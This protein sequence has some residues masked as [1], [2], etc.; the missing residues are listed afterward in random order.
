MRNSISIPR[1]CYEAIKE[2]PYVVQGEVWD[3]VFNYIFNDV[4]TPLEGVSRSAFLLIKPMIEPKQQKVS[5][6]V[7]LADR[8]KQFVD[9][10]QPLLPKYG[11]DLLN[12]FYKYWAEPNQSQ[13][14]MRKELEKTWETERR[15]ETWAKRDKNFQPQEPRREPS[16]YP[17][18]K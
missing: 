5:T 7:P 17:E 15:L 6:L 18:F 3:A 12:D 10:L 16:L 13:T 2:L 8:K 9:E 14:K 11:K 4:I 1:K